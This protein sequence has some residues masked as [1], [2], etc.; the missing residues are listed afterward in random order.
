MT[1]L[2]EQYLLI[3]LPKTF[4]KANDRI[5]LNTLKFLGSPW[6][7][8]RSLISKIFNE[9]LFR[10]TQWMYRPNLKSVALPVP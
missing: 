1:V 5:E 8:T 7:R 4:A 9:L 10:C 6:I 2:V 3:G